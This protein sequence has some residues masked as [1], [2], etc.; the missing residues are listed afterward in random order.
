M[1]GKPHGGALLPINVNFHERR[2]TDNVDLIFFQVTASDS[3]RFDSLVH[4]RSANC[5]N[6]RKVVL[7]HHTGDGPGYRRSARCCGYFQNA[8]LGTRT[9][10]KISSKP[11]SGSCSFVRPVE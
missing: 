9:L 11:L 10:S 2:N 4:R 7:T 3:Q 8:G 5:L 1:Y 6:F